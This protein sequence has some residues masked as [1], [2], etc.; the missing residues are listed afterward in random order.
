MRDFTREVRFALSTT[1]A[2]IFLC[3]QSA[4][5]KAD[6]DEFS[7]YVQPSA[8]RIEEDSSA[9]LL[10]STQL[11]LNLGLS[12][13]AD[14][15]MEAG[16]EWPRR[17]S[18][19]SY[20]LQLGLRVKYDIFRVVPF[21]E[22]LLGFDYIDQLNPSLRLGL[23]AEY[24]YSTKYRFA[25]VARIQ[26]WTAKRNLGLPPSIGFRASWYFELD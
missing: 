24:L 3:F 17:T 18:G 25:L 2:L 20:G 8:Q 11:G 4:R 10:A 7:I 22:A 23:G 12:D 26:P 15:V 13:S 21:A 1:I 5:V 19:P 9:T 6:D 16:L 14:F